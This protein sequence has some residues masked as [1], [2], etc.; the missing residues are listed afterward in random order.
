MPPRSRGEQLVKAMPALHRHKAAARTEAE[1]DLCQRQIEA[2]D[3]HA[4]GGCPGL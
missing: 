4:G 1:R 3:R 2:T